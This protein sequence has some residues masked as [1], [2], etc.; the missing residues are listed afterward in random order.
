MYNHLN[1]VGVPSMRHYDTVIRTS[2]H[3]NFQVYGNY[4]LF[5]LSFFPLFS[6]NCSLCLI[7]IHCESRDYQ[8]LALLFS[9]VFR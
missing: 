9:F 6:D 8:D 2:Q 1:P 4:G 5:F 7:A 3:K